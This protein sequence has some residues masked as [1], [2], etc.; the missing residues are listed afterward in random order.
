MAGMRTVKN[1]MLSEVDS[2]IQTYEAKFKEIQEALQLR[3]ALH[4][5][6]TVMR[7]NDRAESTGMFAHQPFMNCKGLMIL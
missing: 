7:I 6:I 1:V 2:Q 5:G 3:T 4:T